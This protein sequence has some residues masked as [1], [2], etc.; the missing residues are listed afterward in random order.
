MCFIQH[1]FSYLILLIVGSFCAAPAWGQAPTIGKCGV[2]PPNNI[3]NTPIDQLPVATAS[4]TW[5]NTI[6]PAKPLHPDF[7]SDPTIGVPFITVPGTQ[8][9]YPASFTYA[10]ESDPG[11]YAIPLTAPIENGSSSSGDRHAIAVDADNCILYELWSAY[12]QSASW[13]AG[14]G[15]IFNLGSNT[16]RPAGWTSA[17][18][19]G[20]PVFPGLLRY[21]EVAS[22]VVNHAIR[23]TVPQTQ[24]AYLWPARHYA[25][26]LT[27]TQY[28]PMGCPIPPQIHLRHL[29]LLTGEPGDS[30]RAQ[31]V[32]HAACG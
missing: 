9:K 13:T 22:G 8:T 12:P 32:R 6:G 1:R 4:A 19:A 27:G 25:S 21:D 7:G 14:S 18:A 3:W 5:V 23:F 26:T 28:P 16:L 31:K 10:A 2:L 24:R 17:D 30:P 20:L 11:P 15:A 29:G